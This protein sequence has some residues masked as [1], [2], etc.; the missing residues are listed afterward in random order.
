[1]TTKTSILICATLVLSFGI[2]TMSSAY[3]TPDPAKMQQHID[4]VKISHPKEYQYML[5]QAGGVIED[6][7]SCHKELQ[8]KKNASEFNFPRYPQ[9]R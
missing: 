6:C 9:H 4:K 8:T 7:L 2:I 5:D 1:M 3:S